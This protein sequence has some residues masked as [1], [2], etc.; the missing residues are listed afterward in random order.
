MSLVLTKQLLLHYYTNCYFPIKKASRPCNVI[1]SGFI[2]MC[3]TKKKTIAECSQKTI[4]EKSHSA[5]LS[6]SYNVQV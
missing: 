3:L 6:I 2:L 1:L 4:S 5:Y